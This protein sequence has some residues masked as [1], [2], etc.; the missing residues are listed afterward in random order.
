MST[1]VI[2][3]EVDG[4]PA[5]ETFPRTGPLAVDWIA[6]VPEAVLMRIPPGGDTAA[7]LEAWE[8]LTA[9][10]FR[11]RVRTLARGLIGLG[12]ERGDR[13]SIMSR[14]R[15]EWTL[16]S[17][18][19]AYAG[20]VVVPVY[21][22]SAPTQVEWN[23]TDA[24]VSLLVVE[25]AALRAA[26]AV[27]ELAD[28][29]R[30]DVLVIDEGAL[31]RIEEAAASVDEERLDQ[32][33]AS[34]EESDL[35]T[36]VY[37]SGTT[38]RPK[39]CAISH[40]GFL[41]GIDGPLAI[42]GERIS[43]SDSPST[44]LM[45]PLAHIFGR[46]IE[47]STLL[48]RHV[49]VHEPDMTHLVQAFATHRPT[50]IGSVPRVFEKVHASASAAAQAKGERGAKVFAAAEATA[51]EWARTDSPGLGLR[52]RHALFDRLVY[53]KL[54]AA[55]GDECRT[56]IS[57]GSARSEHLSDFFA[58]V[59][60]EIIEG[61]GLTEVGVTSANPPGRTRV[62][63]V[64]VPTPG[65]RMAIDDLGEVLISTQARMTEYHANP[66]ATQAAFTGEWYRTGDLGVIEDGY[67]RIIGRS[68]ELIVT[69]GGKNVAPVVL[70]AGLL[71][72]PLIGQALVVGDNRP[73]IAALLTLDAEAAPAWARTHDI[74][75]GTDLA[76]HPT[77]LASIQEQVEL[78]NQEVSRAESVRAWRL[79]PQE[80]T[81]ESGD[82]TPTMKIKRSVIAERTHDVIDEMYEN[83]RR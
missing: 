58:G 54:R 66:E 80:W 63:T 68:K 52:V 23:L 26:S 18:A 33:A 39:G 51:V 76:S 81:V 19:S 67:L 72:H 64:G 75:E 15:V 71:Q 45:L 69:A 49:L 16:L 60:L 57:G 27:D 42:I 31:A 48:S 36:I 50:Y 53:R 10:G 41:Q 8:S 13:L 56:I 79:L 46:V 12:L 59:G 62:G 30:P 44:V 1:P 32:R 35:I 55:L 77:V 29:D 20:I 78:V 28:V 61:Y 74:P 65:T 43:A 70:E 3:D 82:L 4:G 5:A 73:F 40:S 83:R 14:T 47:A 7:P 37:T 22:T 17:W 34:V 6:E 11:D 21:E 2:V 9:E 38:G 24:G 25:D